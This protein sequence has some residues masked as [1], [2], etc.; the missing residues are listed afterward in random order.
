M[1]VFSTKNSQRFLLAQGLRLLSKP[2]SHGH[3]A[4]FFL[5]VL[6]STS[7]FAF[8]ENRPDVN[9]LDSNYNHAHLVF[10]YQS[11][12]S[13]VSLFGHTFLAFSKTEQLAP[14]DLAVDFNAVTGRESPS[15]IHALWSR[16]LGK[17]E[18]KYFNEKRNEYDSEN[19][20][21][22]IYPI[23]LS[24]EELARLR[25][26]V[27]EKLRHTHGYSFFYDNCSEV[28]HDIVLGALNEGS[29][30][31]GFSSVV[32]PVDSVKKLRTCGYLKEGKYSASTS[33]IVKHGFRQLTASEKRSFLTAIEEGTQVPASLSQ[34]Y[35]DW[36]ILDSRKRKAPYA[37]DSQF[38]QTREAYKNLA[39]AKT[40]REPFVPPAPEKEKRSYIQAGATGNRTVVVKVSPTYK[41]FFSSYEG[42]HKDSEL[43]ALAFD[44]EFN[45][46]L[47]QLNR[48]T[49]FRLRSSSA[50]EFPNYVVGRYLDFSHR[51]SYGHTSLSLGPNFAFSFRGAV[52]LS[53]APYFNI[54][55]FGRD[56]AR[57]RVGFGSL[58]SVTFQLFG[59][60]RIS[61]SADYL[62]VFWGRD[63]FS[64][65]TKAVLFERGSWGLDILAESYPLL[66]DSE[67][68][69]E[70]LLRYRF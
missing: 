35:L 47:F 43:E 3:L 34:L 40:L 28:V 51:H 20:D 2:H 53:T 32:H 54:G 57:M 46:D 5:F 9:Q 64:I 25:S 16:I 68:R 18:L 41:N 65:E 10:A 30:C 55:L 11:D 49:L 62:A 6:Y 33:R 48:F 31:Q 39:L 60:P 21:L 23:T 29:G 67:N 4:L 44:V 50:Y 19:R 42:T 37:Q 58:S 59:G 63:L 1:E 66:T 17:M 45:R 22:W 38:K 7:L 12:T 56:G 13:V 69:Y 52:S 14:D 70:A 15:V 36:S 27:A 26:S 61:V 24:P 8:T